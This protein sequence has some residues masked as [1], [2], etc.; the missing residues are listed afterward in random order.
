MIVVHEVGDQDN[1]GI[2]LSGSGQMTAYDPKRTFEDKILVIQDN[3]MFRQ[4]WGEKEAFYSK[5]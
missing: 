2:E 3:E 5:V 1:E 4:S